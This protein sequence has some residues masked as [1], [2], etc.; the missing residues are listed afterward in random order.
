MV[1]P[2]KFLLLVV[3]AGCLVAAAWFVFR[4][5]HRP[6][7]GSEA[8]NWAIELQQAGRYDKAV[9]VL[10]TWMKGPKRDISHDGFLYQQIA[11]IYIVKAYK[12]PETRDDSIRQSELNLKEAQRLFDLQKVG[13]DDTSLFGIGGAYEILGDISD[14]DRC[15]FY[16]IGRRTLERQLP[17]IKGDSYTAY[18]KTV[19]LEP[20][21]TD[22]RKHLDAVNKK[23]STAGCQAH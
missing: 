15:R 7:S 22:V 6:K 14:K 13:D 19:P 17:L 21:R 4:E 20:L 16:E 11:M 5:A 18:G 9:Q 3:V 2:L 10:Q 23:S 1:I 12:K 8:L